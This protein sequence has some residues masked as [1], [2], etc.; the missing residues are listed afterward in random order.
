MIK[1]FHRG[2]E[3]IFVDIT[4]GESLKLQQLLQLRLNS[5]DVK[6]INTI[7]QKYEPLKQDAFG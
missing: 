3:K 6:Y 2:W 7:N 1:Q 4:L 5:W